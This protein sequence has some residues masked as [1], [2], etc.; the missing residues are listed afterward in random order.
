M[1]EH[2]KKEVDRKP[3]PGRLCGVNVVAVGHSKPPFRMIWGADPRF[4]QQDQTRQPL[5]P[6]RPEPSGA[7][8]APTSKDGA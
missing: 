8:K 5:L 1:V 6:A 2:F 3:E 7:I 4:V